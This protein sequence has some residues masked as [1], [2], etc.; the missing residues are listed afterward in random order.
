M[1]IKQ[2]HTG[3]YA[4]FRVKGFDVVAQMTDDNGSFK[5]SVS[6][7]HGEISRDGNLYTLESFG[8][9][10][11]GSLRESSGIQ[12]KFYEKTLAEYEKA[13]PEVFNT[14]VKTPE[15]KVVGHINLDELNSNTRPKKV[16]KEERDEKRIVRER[17][18]KLGVMGHRPS[19]REVVIFQ[20]KFSNEDFLRRGVAIAYDENHFYVACGLYGNGTNF[21][22]IN[23]PHPDGLKAG[24]FPRGTLLIKMENGMVAEKALGDIMLE[25]YGK[26]MDMYDNFLKQQELEEQ[27][28]KEEA[29]RFERIRKERENADDECPVPDENLLRNILRLS[30][31]TAEYPLV[32]SDVFANTLAGLSR[33]YGTIQANIN[34]RV[35]ALSHLYQSQMIEN[36]EANRT[37]LSDPDVLFSERVNAVLC[38]CGQLNNVIT[39]PFIA[40]HKKISF[41]F[42]HNDRLGFQMVYERT[43]GTLEFKDYNHWVGVN[44][45]SGWKNI[46]LSCLQTILAFL[47]DRYTAI[48]TIKCEY[49]GNELLCDDA[50]SEYLNPKEGEL[51]VKRTVAESETLLPTDGTLKVSNVASYFQTKW[52]RVEGF[53]QLQPV[54]CRVSGYKKIYSNTK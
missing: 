31:P 42:L 14:E 20:K 39:L 41:C 51:Y 24:A 26:D 44:V 5:E 22:F 10:I 19:N 43:K 16:S 30:K 48:N 35:Y 52:K 28:R 47:Y 23:E 18:E 8:E 21:T 45:S 49:S 7:P 37:L 25:K 2:L 6:I 40:S 33:Y 4:T 12:I 17:Q 32:S 3:D 34:N 46:A 53:E 29:E 54:R 15:I 1:K 50:I 27:R 38:V 11:E 9:D 13:H 36:Y